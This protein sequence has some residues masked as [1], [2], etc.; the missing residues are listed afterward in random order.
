MSHDPG[1]QT[2]I[3]RIR[4][5]LSARPLG[6]GKCISVIVQNPLMNADNTPNAVDILLGDGAVQGIL[7]LP[8]Q[9][10]S[11]LFTDDLKDIY[12]RVRTGATE[13][14][15]VVIMHRFPT[16]IRTIKDTTGRTIRK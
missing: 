13:T 3:F 2:N 8:G 7:L 16:P 5:S 9:N 14:D 4:A 10:S 1:T 12:V 15:V 11:E 6:R